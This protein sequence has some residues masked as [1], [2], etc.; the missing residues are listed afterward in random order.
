MFH[1]ASFHPDF[2]LFA[3]STAACS[4]APGDE[5][6][7]PIQDRWAEIKYKLPAKEQADQFHALADKAHQL[8]AANP[9]RRRR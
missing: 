5:L 4:A 8:S 9:N 7:K 3:A 6:V 1:V 2:F